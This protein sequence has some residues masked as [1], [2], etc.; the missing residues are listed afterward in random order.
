MLDQEKMMKRIRI[1][2]QMAPGSVS[3]ASLTAMLLRNP[4]VRSLQIQKG[5]A[6]RGYVNFDFTVRGVRTFWQSL[7]PAFSRARNLSAAA[8]VVC[9]G[10][11]GWDD[12][13]LIHHRDRSQVDRKWGGPTSHRNLARVP[14]AG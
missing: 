12:Y 2:V 4:H 6:S 14:L 13:E 7:R 11:N 8:I 3:V 1:Q 9:E 10:R 5:Q